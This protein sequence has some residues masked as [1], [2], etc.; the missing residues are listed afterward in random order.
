MLW[1]TKLAHIQK[2]KPPLFDTLFSNVQ[3]A[4]VMKIRV[5]VFIVQRHATRATTSGLMEFILPIVT[6]VCSVVKYL[7]WL[8]Q[9]VLLILI[10]Q[11]VNNIFSIIVQ[12]V[13]VKHLNS[14]A[15][16]FVLRHVIKDMS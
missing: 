14:V 7:A 12:L 4:L 1:W 5:F 6:V 9:S 11:Q 16:K 10:V 15:A 13:G 8:D 3:V 2:Q